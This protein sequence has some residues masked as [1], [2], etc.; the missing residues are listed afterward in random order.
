M[1]SAISIFLI[2]VIGIL[3]MIIAMFVFPDFGSLIQ[4]YNQF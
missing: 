1:H 3:A 2:S 4:L